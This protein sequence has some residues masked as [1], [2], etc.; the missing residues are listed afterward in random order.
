[1]YIERQIDEYITDALFRLR[2][3]VVVYGPRQS[4]KTTLLKKILDR[5]GK[6]YLALNAEEQKYHQI[7]S[8]RDS[9]L[10]EGL[11]SG[12]KILFID[13]AQRIEDIG[14][15]LK[16]LHDTFSDLHIIVTGSSSFDLANKVQEP[17]TGR[18]RTFKL[19]PFA[20]CELIK[21][22][23]QFELNERLNEFLIYGSYPEIYDYQNIQDKEEA[24]IDLSSKYLYKDIFELSGIKK[25]RKIEELVRLLAFQVGTPV[26]LNELGN[27]LSMSKDT[28]SSYIDLLEKA[29]VLFRLSGFSRNLRKEVVKMDKVFFIDNGIRNAV[30]NNFNPLNMRNDQGV[31]WENFLISERYKKLIYERSSARMYYWRTYTGAELDYVEDDGSLKGFEFKW[32]EKK[33]KAPKSWLEN[34]G[35]DFR[36]ITPN[37]WQT[38]TL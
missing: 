19:L 35:T 33:V 28:V 23:T 31:L 32:K 6:K 3:V 13:E 18:S 16:I 14:I 4:G 20:S 25:H 27:S 15:N 24:I 10:F 36:V 38:F 37:N 2:K 17:L 5:S 22:L 34:Y 30:I 12:Y 11:I 8:S 9:K 7:L 26:S 1:M 29:F 21:E